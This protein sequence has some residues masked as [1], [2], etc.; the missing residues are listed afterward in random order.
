[1]KVKVLLFASALIILGATIAQ[2]KTVGELFLNRFE[3]V[4]I[5]INGQLLEDSV[6]PPFVVDGRTVLP[7]RDAADR[8]GAF[9]SYNEKKDRVEVTRPNVNLILF[10]DILENYK[11]GY[12]MMYP[13]SKTLVD[14]PVK[15]FVYADVDHAP[16]T[17]ELNVFIRI[18]DPYG[19]EI[20]SSDVVSRDTRKS[21]SFFYMHQLPKKNYFKKT[22]E[23][24]V[25]LL[26]KD[27]VSD[28]YI[29]VGENMILAE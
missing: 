3:K 16:K 11:D 5:S 6:V 25:Q 28:K 2:S 7:L 20:Y 26:M 8:F 18:I 10:K 9:V 14:M 21:G 23:Y 4:K 1:M 12:L 15:F 13:F 17:D 29:V 27:P 22:G 24:H 19:E